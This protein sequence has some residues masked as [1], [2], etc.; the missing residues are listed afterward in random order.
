MGKTYRRNAFNEWGKEGHKAS[1]LDFMSRKEV[2]TQ[3]NC[4]SIH[5][6]DKRAM[7]AIFQNVEDRYDFI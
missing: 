7:R 5:R 4:V 2:L 3:I 1:K 6:E